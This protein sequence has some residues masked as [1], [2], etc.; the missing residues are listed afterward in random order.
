MGDGHAEGTPLMT[1]RIKREIESRELP[2]QRRAGVSVIAH[3]IR[4]GYKK[5][6]LVCVGEC[7]R[8]PTK[9]YCSW[10]YGVELELD[11]NARG[12]S[13][14]AFIHYIIAMHYVLTMA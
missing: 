10:K 5:H 1:K 14:R 2:G 7:S 6:P 4:S 8:K 9:I 13:S 12:C 3:S 11:A